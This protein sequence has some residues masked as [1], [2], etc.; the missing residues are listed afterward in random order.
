MSK[1]VDFTPVDCGD[2]TEIPPDAPAGGW[3]ALCSVKKHKTAKDGFPML[4]LEWRLEK[5]HE[6][7][8]EN[9][10]GARVTDFVT[11]FPSNHNA[12]RM[13]RVRLKSLCEALK[14]DP[15]ATSKVSS[16][17]DIADFIDALD[18]C[19]A[20]IY[21]TVAPR[22]DTGELATSV[23]YTSPNGMAHTNGGR[24]SSSNEDEDDSDDEDERPTPKAKASNGN[25]GARLGPNGRP[26]KSKK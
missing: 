7:E 5:A 21:T 23:R 10:V 8:N 13:S 4:I 24:S 19:R 14:I 15:P 22:K 12:C 25:S 1:T 26:L 18:G 2:M 16:W 20:P 3:D 9:H 6:D 17:D 11:F